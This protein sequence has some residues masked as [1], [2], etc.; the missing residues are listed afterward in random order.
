MDL[1]DPRFGVGKSGGIELMRSPLA[2]GPIAPILDD[3][4]EGDTAF[5]KAGDHVEAFR[6]GFI[7]LAGLPEGHRP[8]W[9]HGCLAGKIAIAADDIVDGWA[10]EEIVIHAVAHF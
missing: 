7:S 6:G 8:D 4:V 5:A 3:V 9:H 1:V 2:F 10:G